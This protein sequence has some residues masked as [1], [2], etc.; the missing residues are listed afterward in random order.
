M[1]YK[2]GISSALRLNDT[3]PIPR[4]YKELYE[5]M[6]R[7]GGWGGGGKGNSNSTEE[8]AQLPHKQMQRYSASVATK[9]RK[10]VLP[11]LAYILK[12][13]LF[14]NHLSVEVV[15]ELPP[16]ADWSTDQCNNFRKQFDI[17]TPSNF[18]TSLNICI[19]LAQ[20]F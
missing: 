18:A 3:G 9:R 5:S 12:I 8:E 14:L 13:L 4:I 19:S 2:P 11:T 15:W 7:C 10:S 16:T 20:Q 6:R 17:R 1:S